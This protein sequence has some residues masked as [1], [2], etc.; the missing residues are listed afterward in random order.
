[1]KDFIEQLKEP[2][3]SEALFTDPTLLGLTPLLQK[4]LHPPVS[5]LDGVSAVAG[6]RALIG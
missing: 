5:V 2:G 1:M 3:P 4:L 6:S